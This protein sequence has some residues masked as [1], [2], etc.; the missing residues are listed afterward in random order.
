MRLWDTAVQPPKWNE[1]GVAEALLVAV[2]ARPVL[3]PLD[4]RFHRRRRR[5]GRLWYH[6]VED[7][8]KVLSRHPCCAHHR[9]EPAA[10]R[11]R[12]PRRLR[13]ARPAHAP[14]APQPRG[15]L[16]EYLR[17]AAA[18]AAVIELRQ[19]GPVLG[20]HRARAL[21]PQVFRIHPRPVAFGTHAPVLLLARRVH[22]IAKALRVVESPKTHPCV[23]KPRRRS[24]PVRVPHVHRHLLTCRC[25]RR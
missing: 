24:V 6:C 23:R 21:K 3:D 10:R 12:G 5:V 13:H 1:D 15:D 7:L 14:V 22:T 11:E 16:L 25:G 18:P 17:A 20:A 4:R 19:K 2:A 9:L 8:P